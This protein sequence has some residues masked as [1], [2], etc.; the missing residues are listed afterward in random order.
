MPAAPEEQRNIEIIKDPNSL[1]RFPNSISLLYITS[2]GIY[3][4]MM[5]AIEEMK[6]F[7]ERHGLPVGTVRVVSCH[8]FQ[9]Q[10]IFTTEHDPITLCTAN[11]QILIASDQHSV[12]VRDLEQSGKL[13]HSFLTIDLVQ[14]IIH[15]QTGN[16]IA[17]LELKS[18]RQ[19]I[20]IYYV[21]VY[22]NWWMG[23]KDQTMKARIAG[24]VTPSCQS[25]EA[26]F[27]MVEIPLPQGA[28]GICCCQKSGNLAVIIGSTISIFVL[29]VKVHDISKLKFV[30][31]NHLANVQVSF[32]I[33][34]I[35][36]CEDYV[37]C[38]N[39]KELQ[40]FRVI[41]NSTDYPRERSFAFIGKS[42]VSPKLSR[43]Q[44]S[45]N[46]KSSADEVDESNCVVWDFNKALLNQG[47][48]AWKE[49]LAEES[50]PL[51]VHLNSLSEEN[52]FSEDGR[53]GMEIC[54]VT[55]GNIPA[56]PVAAEL[57]PLFV[58]FN[59]KIFKQIKMISL[60]YKRIPSSTII[61]DIETNCLHSMVFIPVYE[62][63]EIEIKVDAT[64]ILTNSGY[65]WPQRQDTP[66]SS[67]F[68][69]SLRQMCFFV[70]TPNEGFL[71]D[72]TDMD[73]CLACQYQYTSICKSV[74]VDTSSI[75]ALTEAGLET[76]TGRVTH[77][78]MHNISK[79][80]NDDVSM[81]PMRDDPVCLLDLRPFLNIE[82]MLKSKNHIILISSK[83]FGSSTESLSGNEATVY[84][85]QKPL[86]EVIHSNLMDLANEMKSSSS[87]GYQ[88]L[89]MEA[90]MQIKGH[91]LSSKDDNQQKL[92]QHWCFLVANYYL[93]SQNADESSNCLPYFCMS[94]LPL[95]YILNKIIKNKSVTKKSLLKYL[96]YI[97]ISEK[98]M[99]E[100]SLL[101][102][103]IGD[104]ILDFFEEAECEYIGTI[105]LSS[106]LHYK[107][108]KSI[109]I[110][111]KQIAEK[112]KFRAV[113]LNVSDSIPPLA[114]PTRPIPIPPHEN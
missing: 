76:Y 56:H 28:Q 23:D 89:L 74:I 13:V 112:K 70:S 35:S 106:K 80:E 113:V 92:Y 100:V 10:N 72:M 34:Q 8:Y 55:F 2:F 45:Q 66:L 107:L 75:H 17:C 77:C 47:K 43:I 64:G 79:D 42:E 7:E 18:S 99:K 58:S 82:Y 90:G 68:R 19:S 5:P 11:E 94:E 50:W 108:E 109:Q 88:H 104:S 93:C 103:A 86:P 81:Y 69:S 25:V 32:K 84:C 114:D 111:R 36:M 67:P 37:A 110:L 98:Y 16:Y 20:P 101:P 83:D 96:K 57:D 102:Q 49:L 14:Q 22:L 51:T 15:C 59:K 40:V 39:T 21:R 4:F 87:C 38:S 91:L 6:P 54:G 26:S 41:V 95:E 27:E 61:G 9:S 78:A 105:V 63:D 31:F 24:R 12:E 48:N 46:E 62:S 3:A 97:L 44:S 71:Y 85:L 33:K 30:D 1:S 73:V 65:A 53:E 52:N 29:S 60:L